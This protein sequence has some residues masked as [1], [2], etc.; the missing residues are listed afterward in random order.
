MSVAT[1]IA[2]HMTICTYNGHH[3]GVLLGGNLAGGGFISDKKHF[4][5][6][7]RKDR[8]TLIYT[9]QFAVLISDTGHGVAIIP[10]VGLIDDYDFI[11]VSAIC[12]NV[13]FYSNDLIGMNVFLDVPELDVM[14]LKLLSDRF[15]L[16]DT[17]PGYIRREISDFCFDRESVILARNGMLLTISARNSCVYDENEME[18]RADKPAKITRHVGIYTFVISNDVIDGAD[19]HEY[20][21]DVIWYVHTNNVMFYVD[22]SDDDLMAI[23][24]I[25][26]RSCEK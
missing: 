21:D 2:R 10:R 13:M 15:I 17:L 20:D 1:N 4:I 18:V 23:V 25:N 3:P 24:G 6:R 22:C 11:K 5:N 16:V 12:G 7:K 26:L 14:R 9:E 19:T 8:N